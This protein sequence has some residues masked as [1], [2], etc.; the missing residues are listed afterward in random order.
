MKEAFRRVPPGVLA[1]C[2]AALLPACQTAQIVPKIPGLEPYRMTIQ[3]GNNLSQEMVAQLKLGMTREQV[4]FVLGTPLL[5]D[6]F[7]ADRWDYVYYREIP[8][9]KREQR[10]LSVLF[11]KDKLVRVLGDLVPPEGTVVQ[12][13]GFVPQTKPEAPA[14]PAA[15]AA[16]PAAEAA[17]PAAEA[18]KPAAEAPRPVAESGETK[19]NWGSA[20]Q[21]REA[22]PAPAASEEAKK[23]EDKKADES[24]Q[25]PA[26]DAPE[27][28]F[29]ER[30]RQKLGL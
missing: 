12:P 10:N 18:P 23:P 19:Q 7:H 11:E 14:K 29:F 1:L 30:M 6:V 21:E 4:R 24:A 9:G 22:Q 28:G 20:T 25:K 13:T 27:P 15:A 26:A 16:R 5:M 3:Q 2:V 17:K 8:G